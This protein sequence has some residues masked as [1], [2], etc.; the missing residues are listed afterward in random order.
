[1]PWW[2]WLIIWTLLVLALLGMLAGAGV[3]LFRKLMKTAR[4]L[5]D[6]G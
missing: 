1:M 6:L 3:T 4:A 2:S 5:H